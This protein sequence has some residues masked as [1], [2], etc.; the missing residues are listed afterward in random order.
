MI[1]LNLVMLSLEIAPFDATDIGYEPDTPFRC[2]LSD[3]PHD[4]HGS[5]LRL[6]P[7]D[8]RQVFFFW[9]AVGTTDHL[10]CLSPCDKPKPEHKEPCCLWRGHSGE[11]EWAIIDPAGI[12]VTAALDQAGPLFRELIGLSDLLRGLRPPET[13]M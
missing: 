10:I 5:F 6:V 7:H 2:D 13:E 4:T 9:D 12:A 8:D 11:C 1:D 3:E